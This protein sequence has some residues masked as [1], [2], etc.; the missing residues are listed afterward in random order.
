MGVMGPG[1]GALAEDCQNAYELGRAIA[2]GGLGADGADGPRFLTIVRFRH[3][4]S[5]A[6]CGGRSFNRYMAEDRQ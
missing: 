4:M 1:E 3:S 2:N 5:I 6:H